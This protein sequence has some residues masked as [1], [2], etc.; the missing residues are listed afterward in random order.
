MHDD[1]KPKE[2][3]TEPIALAQ[4]PTPADAALGDEDRPEEPLRRLPGHGHV[5]EP[6]QAVGVAALVGAAREAARGRRLPAEHFGRR[7]A[8]K[9]AD[10]DHGPQR[11]IVADAP[12]AA[13]RGGSSATCETCRSLF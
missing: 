1:D 12:R 5:R 2:P 11:S 8:R 6:L 10:V 4:E 13:A 7:M 9:E 3:H